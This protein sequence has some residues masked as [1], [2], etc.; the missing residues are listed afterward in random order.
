[1]D[2][3]TTQNGTFDELVDFSQATLSG[4]TH[5]QGILAQARQDL[6]ARSRQN[7][8]DPEPVTDQRP[9]PIG[10]RYENPSTTID[11]TGWPADGSAIVASAAPLT[12]S[13]QQALK[14]QAKIARQQRRSES[15]YAATGRKAHASMATHGA[16]SR[17]NNYGRGGQGSLRN[18]HHFSARAGSFMPAPGNQSMSINPEQQQKGRPR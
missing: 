8:Q 7:L 6:L 11:K 9:P 4:Q 16:S 17:R 1:M 12:D 15:Q 10:F 2:K 5:A 13:E 18:Q 14:A 3:T